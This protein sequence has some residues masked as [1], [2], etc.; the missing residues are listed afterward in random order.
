MKY[1]SLLI[2]A[3]FTCFSLTSCDDK[4]DTPEESGSDTPSIGG[5]TT[6]GNGESKTIKANEFVFSIMDTYYLYNEGISDDNGYPV[7]DY[8]K[9]PDT[10]EYFEKLRDKRDIFSFI[11]DDAEAYNKEESGITTDMGW[12]ASLM[13]GDAERKT[14][15]A[16]I[17]YVYEGTPAFEAGVKRGDYVVQVNEQQ[18]T[19]SNYQKLWNSDGK[20]TIFRFNE[21]EE[22]ETLTV[23]LKSR[24]INISP[25]AEANIYTLEDGT[26][27][28]YLL[29]MGFKDKFDNELTEVFKTFGSEGVSKL[30]LDLR[31]NPGGAMV[32][33][34]HLASL[35]A[36]IDAVK[37]K[38]QIIHYQYN[39]ILQK[40]IGTDE[41]TF[42]NDLQ[43]VDANLN[44]QDIVIIQG[45]GTYSAS[46]V[47]IIGLKPYMNV[48]TIGSTSGGKNTA[49]Y[50]LTPDL[51]V[52]QKTGESIFDKSINN[53]L[54]APLVAIYYNSD[55]YTFDTTDGDGMEPDY[56]YNE[57][58]DLYR[59]PLGNPNEKLTS[60]ALE[61]IANGDIAETKSARISPFGTVIPAENYRKIEPLKVE[62]RIEILK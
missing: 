57:F 51:F 24:E 8:T 56:A 19:P 31:Y 1:Y 25:V 28:G 43:V 17:N 26:K 54:I 48:Y 15:L 32:A 40:E 36:P 20:Y 52:N 6:S 46:E 2:A 18:M 49:M 50:I 4:K 10:K 29:Y 30:I 21:K 45:S 59:A 14:V 16:A 9:E 62:P 33:C 23:D 39:K 11:T 41:S 61:Y 37:A 44:L 38:K 35:I 34:S 7:I 27:V 42:V 60:L 12:E 5:G 47:T 53:W 55:N 22:R 58:D 13:Y 3:L